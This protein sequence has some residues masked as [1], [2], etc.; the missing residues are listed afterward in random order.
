MVQ[1]ALRNLAEE[2]GSTVESISAYILSAYEGLPWGHDKLLPYY[3]GKLIVTGELISP[4]PGR[5]Q[6]ALQPTV[7][8]FSSDIP[9]P[10]GPCRRRGRPSLWRGRGRPP[11]KVYLPETEMCLHRGR[12]RKTLRRRRGRPPLRRG[13]DV[14]EMRNPSPV[15]GLQITSENKMSQ[16]GSPSK[17][18]LP[19]AEASLPGGSGTKTLRRRR[20]RP[21]LRRGGDVGERQSPNQALA[22]EVTS[23]HKMNQDGSPSE[24]YL[25]EAE[26]RLLRGR[27]M[28][29]LRRRRGRPPLR[30]GDDVGEMRSSSPVLRPPSPVLRLCGTSENDMSQDAFLYR[31]AE[32]WV[33]MKA[34]DGSGSGS[35]G[36]GGGKPSIWAPRDD[37]VDSL[38]SGQGAS[39][40]GDAPILKSPEK[41]ELDCRQSPAGEGPPTSTALVL[42]P[43]GHNAGKRAGF[44]GQKKARGK[45]RKLWFQG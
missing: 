4:S 40:A 20:G 39:L 45:H 9:P 6:S 7:T 33:R 8:L 31:P 37:T 30:R 34:Q 43:E 41:P 28:K 10:L 35:G 3:L 23:E 18:Y 14:G 5:Y 17:V 19:E 2:G 26:T 25:P 12:G 44:S 24:V 36:G 21:P 32:G 13:G 27:G 15:P 11:S 1:A 38:D 22:L 29:T 42:V 16:D